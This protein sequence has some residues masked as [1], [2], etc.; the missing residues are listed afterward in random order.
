[1][2]GHSGLF[3]PLV[4]QEN[5]IRSCLLSLL[6]L[7]TDDPISNNVFFFFNGLFFFYF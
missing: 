3:F 5:L 4:L 7:N 2:L 6:S 1:M